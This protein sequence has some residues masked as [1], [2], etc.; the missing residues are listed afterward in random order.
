MKTLDQLDHEEAREALA[1]FSQMEAAAK[2][3]DVDAILAASTNMVAE[4]I[5]RGCD[6]R[7]EAEWIADDVTAKL[8]ETIARYWSQSRQSLRYKRSRRFTARSTSWWRERRRK[9]LQTR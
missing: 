4:T 6:S 1:L 2:G 3:R 5:L 8:S 7:K 9:S